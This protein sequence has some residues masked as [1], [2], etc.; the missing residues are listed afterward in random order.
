MA[1]STTVVA[2]VVAAVVRRAS[3][4]AK[5][6]RVTTPAPAVAGRTARMD[7]APALPAP[8]SIATVSARSAAVT[9]RAPEVRPDAAMASAGSVARAA[10]AQPSSA[11]RLNAPARVAVST[12]SPRTTVPVRSAGLH[13]SAATVAA[14]GPDKSAT[15]EA[16][17]RHAARRNRGQRPATRPASGRGAAWSRIGV[18]SWWTAARV[19]RS[20]AGLASAMAKPRTVATRRCKT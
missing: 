4:L 18:G 17:F 12:P 14:V 20:R 16:R 6:V 15:R 11:G 1:V 7:V 10:T 5:I 3:P 19:R 2:A 13:S 9:A 8:R